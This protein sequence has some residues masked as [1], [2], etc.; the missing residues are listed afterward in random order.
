[1]RLRRDRSGPLA[2]LLL[3]VVVIALAAAP[4]AM[5]FTTTLVAKNGRPIHGKRARWLRQS[6][7]P[8]VHGRIRLITAGCPG[9]PLFSGCV[10]SGR[11]RTLYLRPGAQNPKAVIYHELGHTFDMT[12]LRR[13]DRT[14]FKKALHLKGRGWFSGHGPP[15]ELFAEAYA[16]CSRFGLKRPPASKL[17]WTRSLYGYRP[18]R[19]QHRAA[20][21][22]ILNAGADKR[23]RAKPKPQPP[24]GAPPV[25]EQKSPQ[26][27]S[28]QPGGGG[29]IPGLP[30]PLPLPTTLGM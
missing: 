9:R 10:F 2:A 27:P 4:Q 28:R 3:G 14:A 17:G 21:S 5:A 8:I 6:K 13:R 29:G 11:P 15:A 20:C 23:Q 22:L 19:S 25:I 1:M 12:L 26:P 7:M 24:A 18:T 30:V 16:L